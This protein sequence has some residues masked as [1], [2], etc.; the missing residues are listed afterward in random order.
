MPE[1]IDRPRG[2]LRRHGANAV[3]Q[4]TQGHVVAVRR[5][6]P[7]L[8]PEDARQGG[9]RRLDLV[10]RRRAR[11]S[12]IDTRRQPSVND[13]GTTNLVL[14]QKIRHFHGKL[15][16]HPRLTTGGDLQL[17]GAV[18][19][20]DVGAQRRERLKL[21]QRR[22]RSEQRRQNRRGIGV[23]RQKGKRRPVG[24]ILREQRRQTLLDKRKFHPHAQRRLARKH[25]YLKPLS[26]IGVRDGHL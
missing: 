18:I 23:V 7:R 21:F 12:P 24:K 14:I 6:K 1:K 3:V 8:A 25:P 15:P 22:L 17:A 5:E 10:R 16:R 13:L 11:R 2:T 4:L 20:R 9:F 26:D 19:A